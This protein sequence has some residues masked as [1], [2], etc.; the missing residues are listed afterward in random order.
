LSTR[1]KRLVGIVVAGV[2]LSLAMLTVLPGMA[3]AQEADPHDTG[4]VSTEAEQNITTEEKGAPAAWRPAPEPPTRVVRPGDSLWLISQEQLPSNATP[5][6][7]AYEVERVFELNRD[8]I[9]DNPDLILPGQEL[10][11]TPVV[12]QQPAW[13]IEPRAEKPVATATPAPEDRQAVES[14]PAPAAEP[15]LQAAYPQA[16]PNQKSV[17]VPASESEAESSAT[18]PPDL[19]SEQLGMRSLIVIELYFVG[20]TI[21]AIWAVSKVPSRQSGAKDAKGSGAGSSPVAPATAQKPPSEA[22][23]DELRAER[24]AVEEQKRR[25]ATEEG[26]SREGRR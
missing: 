25:Q 5:E 16:E 3:E 22:L 4:A 19:P 7:I 17:A 8:H 11:L 24:R 1:L 14:T 6:Q 13:E 20:A 12:E 26:R 9:G 15:T 10:L 21:L 2:A 23:M 18:A